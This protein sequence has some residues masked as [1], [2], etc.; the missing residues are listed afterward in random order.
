M[1]PT[2]RALW[3]QRRRWSS[4]LGQALRDYGL[5]ALFN[6]ARHLPVV[7]ITL[8]NVVW[9]AVVLIQ[10]T[11]A[12][13]SLLHSLLST[14][15]DASSLWP[16]SMSF[17]TVLALGFVMFFVQFAVATLVDGR[18]KVHHLGLVPFVPF[19]WIYFWTILTTSFLIGFP[20][21]I[22]SKRLGIWAPT[23]RQ[24]SITVEGQTP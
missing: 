15:S 3:R 20:K 22:A 23:V 7:T 2:W 14:S 13:S 12:L 16:P 4:G 21:G 5:S 18:R 8:P 17:L 10:V 9:V 6:G 24:A 19:Y 1:A 11:G